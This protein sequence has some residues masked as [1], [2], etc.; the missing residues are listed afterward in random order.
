MRRLEL[1]DNALAVL[2]SRYLRRDHLLNIVESPAELLGRVAGHVARAE[3]ISGTPAQAGQWEEIFLDTMTA[4]DF[5]PNSPTLM[6][7]GTPLRQLSA[8]F[9]IPVEDTM[10]DIFEALKLMALVQRSGGGTGFSFSGLRPASDPIFS[11]GG[12]ASG[13]VSFMKIFDCTTTYIKQGG[14]RRGANM[15]VLRVDHPDILD[16]VRAKTDG[17]ALQNFNLSVGVTDAFMEA[18]AQNAWYDLVHPARGRVRSRVRAGDVFQEIVQAAWETG[19]PGLL[20][21][22]AVN[23]A[24]PTPHV[25]PIEATNPCGEIPLLDYESCNLGSLNLAHMLDREG[26]KIDA[27]KLRSTV[28]KGV[29]FLDNVISVNRYPAKEIQAATEGNRKIGLGVM[30][31]SEMLIRM[32]ISY[33][34]PDAEKVASHV[35]KAINDE[36]LRTSQELAGERGAYP[37]WKGS[38]HD[39]QGIFVRN[40]TRTAIAPTGTIGIIADTTP[41]IEPLFALAYRLEHVLEGHDLEEVHPL[42]REVADRYHL[43]TERVVAQIVEK[44]T[45]K[46]AEGVP[47]AMRNVF[48]TAL[49]IPVEQHLA[50]QAAFQRHVDN[51]VSKTINIPE[52]APPSEVAKAYRRAWELGLKGITIYR[53]GSRSEQVLNLGL[54]EKAYHYDHGS[55]CDPEEC[56]I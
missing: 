24:N 38:V 42:F 52:D 25:G 53:Y 49:E 2:T 13:P 10:E 32:G 21:M 54:K 7:A 30:G 44:G 46:E 14:K 56:R 50:I 35:M 43:D 37:N 18:V 20:F 4:R 39:K 47:E 3:L 31:F 8:C 28:Q 51:S 36:A 23:R 40:A 15:G 55:R 41:S 22:D 33:A 5:L 27:A 19:D 34:S 26:T 11:T 16:F 9:V 17:Q 12:E 1:S 48:K 29:R 6:N 45:L